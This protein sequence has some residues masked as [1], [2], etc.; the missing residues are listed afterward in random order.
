MIRIQDRDR[1]GGGHGWAGANMVF[2]NCRARSIDCQK[3]PTAN[4]YCIGCTGKIRGS[5]H[6]ASHG[7]P[8]LPR[9]LYLRQLADRLGTGAVRNAATEAQLSGAI[10]DALKKRLS[11]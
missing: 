6:I 5:G 11:E 2:W 10:D 4:N 8:V 9:S 1:M 7:K 3:P